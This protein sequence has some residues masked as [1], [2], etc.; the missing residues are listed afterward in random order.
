LVVCTLGELGGQ[1]S[2]RC[3]FIMYIA[4]RALL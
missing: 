1:T 2:L 4:Y 3:S